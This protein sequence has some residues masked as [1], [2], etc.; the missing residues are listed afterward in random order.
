MRENKLE[1]LKKAERVFNKRIFRAR[2][3]RIAIMSDQ[4][5]MT[6][7][8]GI[9]GKKSIDND[10]ENQMVIVGLSARRLFALADRGEQVGLVDKSQ[11]VT[12]YETVQNYLI[13]W[14]RL[15]ENAIHRRDYPREELLKLEDLAERVFNIAKHTV[16]E[17][18]AEDD[19]IKHLN[20][21]SGLDDTGGT[22]IFTD[23]DMQKSVEI[24]NH[25]RTEEGR[26]GVKVIEDRWDDGPKRESL[27]EW[28]TGNPTQ[29]EM[30][31]W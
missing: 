9:S 26:S 24:Q 7:G 8:V 13:S 14:H 12:F 25:S 11:L 22:S 1:N 5:I 6:F 28:L 23:K 31:R 27:K 21:L 16:E 15:I 4:E 29:R 2:V 18:I 30:E 3:R 10:I 19:F 17:T 20:Q